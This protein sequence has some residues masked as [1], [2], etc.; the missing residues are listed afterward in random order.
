[1]KTIYKIIIFLITIFILS[2]FFYTFFSSYIPV[3]IINNNIYYK[4][5]IDLRKKITNIYLDTLLTKTNQTETEKNNLS[6]LKKINYQLLFQSIIDDEIIAKELK[7]LPNKDAIDTQV[8]SVL[9]S[10]L[11]DDTKIKEF[12]SVYSISQK[13]FLN[14]VIIPQIKRDIFQDHFKSYEEKDNYI[15]SKR[16]TLKIINLNSSINIVDGEVLSIV[17]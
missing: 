12:L 16:V 4:K 9:S 11:Q 8:N 17:D 1:M 2:L 15:K 3:I 13:D 5:E 7:D 14:S 6:T 10:T